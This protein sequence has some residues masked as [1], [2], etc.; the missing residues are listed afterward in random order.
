MLHNKI[1][2]IL[3]MY[4]ILLETAGRTCAFLFTKLS[5]TKNTIHNRQLY[6]LI[7][8]GQ[9]CAL[10]FQIITNFHFNFTIFIICL[11]ICKT[12]HFLF[13]VLRKARQYLMPIYFSFPL[14]MLLDITLITAPS[15]D[16]FVV[17]YNSL[18]NNTT[19]ENLFLLQRVIPG[20][21]QMGKP[22]CT[23]IKR[24]DRE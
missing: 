5:I 18:R 14:Q 17:K 1:G 6:I 22:A 23:G 2:W 10:V 3:L 19:V 12:L 7:S 20:E 13:F 8:A 24:R 9:I 21:L 11:C 4:I 15:R 16:R